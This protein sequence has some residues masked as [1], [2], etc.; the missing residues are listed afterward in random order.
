LAGLFFG[1]SLP[2][3]KFAVQIDDVRFR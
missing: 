1:A 3:G 2:A